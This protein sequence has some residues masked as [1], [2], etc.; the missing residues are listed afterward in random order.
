MPK[1]YGLGDFNQ[2]TGNAAMRLS[3]G[4]AEAL[5]LI[6]AS[7][8][9]QPLTLVRFPNAELTPGMMIY[10]LQQIINQV[11]DKLGGEINSISSV[12]GAIKQR[13]SSLK[14]KTLLIS[15]EWSVAALLTAANDG[16]LRNTYPFA[17]K[18]VTKEL[19]SEY[20]QAKN[21]AYAYAI[22]VP[23]GVQSGITELYNYFIIDATDGHMLY[24]TGNSKVMHGYIDIG[25]LRHAVSEAEGR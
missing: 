24:W 19:L 8:P 10:V 1:N 18:V 2:S 6:W 11:D 5:A 9:N 13:A 3:V 4:R 7:K 21:S 22:P 14:D 23:A 25:H 17:Y 20:I 12:K 15:E 16:E